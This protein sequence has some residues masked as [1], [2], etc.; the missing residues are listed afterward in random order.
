MNIISHEVLQINHNKYSITMNTTLNPS[1]TT[2]CACLLPIDIVDDEIVKVVYM[3]SNMVYYR[4]TLV[5]ITT[6]LR[7][8]N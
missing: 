1:N 8:L 7:V 4:C 2:S 5:F 3:T 6:S